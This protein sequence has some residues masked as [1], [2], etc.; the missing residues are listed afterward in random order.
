[1]LLRGWRA[2]CLGGVCGLTRGKEKKSETKGAPE[3]RNAMASSLDAGVCTQEMQCARVRVHPCAQTGALQFWSGYDM[4]ER[5]CTRVWALLRVANTHQTLTQ[6]CA[7]RDAACACS[8]S[9]MCTSKH[10]PQLRSEYSRERACTRVC[11]PY[12]VPCCCLLLWPCG[13]PPAV[14]VWM[15]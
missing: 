13:T 2:C 5:A 6:A 12:L 3:G 14:V 10:K 7:H 8:H 4:R 9:S 1:M 11:A 15:M